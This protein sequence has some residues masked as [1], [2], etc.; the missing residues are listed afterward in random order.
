MTGIDEKNLYKKDAQFYDLD[1]RDVTKVDIPFYLK[2]AVRVNGPI[3]ELACGTGRVAIPLAEAGYEMWGL[4]YSEKMIE[5]FQKKVS[6]LPGEVAARIHIEHGDMSHFSMG[7]QFPMILLP[8]RSFQLL[9]DEE[10]EKSCLK[11]VKDHLSANGTFIIDVANFGQRIG[12][13]WGTDNEY[14]DWENVDPRTGYTIR[15]THIRK[16]IDLDRQIIT[17]Q[18][19]YRVTKDDG[20]VETIIK[21]SP[22]RYFFENQIRELLV[23]S[24]F[25]IVNE[26]GNYDGEP[27]AKDMPE[28][29]FVCQK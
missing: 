25:K 29:I 17:P 18:K 20:T 2:Q 14:F 3:L 11:M 9:L 19:I 1:T 10:L 16:K 26:F 7:R 27:I 5:Q 4:E 13:G 12:E 15:R 28:F 8:C 6:E 22:W 21:H 24:G 23:S